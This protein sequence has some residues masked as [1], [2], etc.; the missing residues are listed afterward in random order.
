MCLLCYY[1]RGGCE[2]HYCFEKKSQLCFS[3]ARKYSFQMA[4]TIL[5]H[6]TVVFISMI[7]V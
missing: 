5:Q 7:L 3:V 2:N 6:F 1:F 4:D